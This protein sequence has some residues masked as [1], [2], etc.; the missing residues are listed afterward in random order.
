MR[1]NSLTLHVDNK[2]ALYVA[3]GLTFAYFGYKQCK[4]T[5]KRRKRRPPTVRDPCYRPNRRVRLASW[6]PGRSGSPPPSLYVDSNA[7][8]TRPTIHVT[9][10]YDIQENTGSSHPSSRSRLPRRVNLKNDPTYGDIEENCKTAAERIDFG[11]AHS[12]VGGS[13]IDHMEVMSI[14]SKCG[15]GTVDFLESEIEN[16][17]GRVEDHVDRDGSFGESSEVL[18]QLSSMAHTEMSRPGH[19]S[20]LDVPHPLDDV[21]SITSFRTAE[22]D[23]MPEVPSSPSSIR[24]HSSMD[25]THSTSEEAIQPPDF[26]PT[27]QTVLESEISKLSSRL[28]RLHIAVHRLNSA[29][30]DPID[31][32]FTAL[33]QTSA[34]KD[35]RKLI[36][37][38]TQDGLSLG[39]VHYHDLRDWG[40][41]NA[42][43]RTLLLNRIKQFAEDSDYLVDLFNL[44]PQNSNFRSYM[45]TFR[46]HKVTEDA[47]RWIDDQSLRAFG[48]ESQMHRA[49]I[50]QRIE[51]F[52]D[53]RN[54]LSLLFKQLPQDCDFR[55]YH[56]VFEHHGVTEDT[57][58][59][60][61][62]ADLVA[63]GI[64]N[65]KHRKILLRHMAASLYCIDKIERMSS[66]GNLVDDED[67]S[68]LGSDFMDEIYHTPKQSFA[69]SVPSKRLSFKSD[70]KVRVQ[71]N[72]ISQS[73]SAFTKSPYSLSD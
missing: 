72:S 38:K 28:Q 27:M 50:V 5:P 61:S 41:T 45:Q 14:A 8:E 17:T 1:E 44:L 26:A 54:Y 60:L 43:H 69:S 19:A 53:G 68:S 70:M 66:F 55:F 49:L 73:D 65:E 23:D 18:S 67:D 40:I 12:S 4:S 25:S 31:Q 51:E 2:N 7:S 9:T 64:V 21:M 24:K 63:M 58:Q 46:E 16:E 36:S 47:L 13:V 62:N 52:I 11:D 10:L 42:H 39:H 37:E 48:V 20:A 33:P 30:E 56:M 32:L 22:I 15:G 29:N 3:A 34:F 35:Y 71:S 6:A 59:K 57:I